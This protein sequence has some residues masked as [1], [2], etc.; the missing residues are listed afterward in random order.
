MESIKTK[1]DQ[2]PG[3][4]AYAVSLSLIYTVVIFNCSKCLNIHSIPAPYLNSAAFTRYRIKSARINGD[5]CDCKCRLRMLS[6]RQT[7][8]IHRNRYVIQLVDQFEIDMFKFNVRSFKREKTNKKIQTNTQ[9]N[10]LQ[11]NVCNVALMR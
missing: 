1:W 6:V 8:S 5:N 2:K 9:T 10:R 7:K 11:R 3:N 4:V